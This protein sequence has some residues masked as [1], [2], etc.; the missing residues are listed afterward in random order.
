MLQTPQTHLVTN[1]IGFHRNLD[2]GGN[3]LRLDAALMTGAFLL[4]LP[5]WD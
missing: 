4:A 5:L 2:I 3:S 1:R